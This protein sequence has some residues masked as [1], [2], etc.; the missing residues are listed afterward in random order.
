M[1][2]NNLSLSHGMSSL[3]CLLLCFALLGRL[4]AETIGY[5]QFEGTPDEEVDVVESEVN[6]ADFSGEGT[7][8]NSDIVPVYSDDVVTDKDEAILDGKG[9]PVLNADNK[10]SLYFSG[11]TEQEGGVVSIQDN[12]S[13]NSL[14]EPDSFTVEFFVKCSETQASS[15]LVGKQI[16]GSS[17]SSWSIKSYWRSDKLQIQVDS[18]P[19]KRGKSEYDEISFA[20]G[21]WHHIALTYDA[22]TST[23][24]LY[25]DYSAVATLKKEVQYTDEALQIG[26]L[27][28][29]MA[30]SGLIDEL[31][32]SSE[33]LEPKQF[34]HVGRPE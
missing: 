10:T 28:G 3:S 7:S 23:F 5:W 16:G 2:K 12:S 21:L 31:R 34:L 1:A 9:G 14:L 24:T 13:D 19:F 29:G 15:T 25:Q 4:E 20:D 6:A 22:A 33:V 26:N 17:A 30:F 32:Y 8:H 11:G 18:L 27:A